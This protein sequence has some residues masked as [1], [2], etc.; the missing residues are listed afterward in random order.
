M[1]R[2]KLLLAAMQSRDDGEI[3]ALHRPIN[4]RMIWRLISLLA[5]W[6]QAYVGVAVAGLTI[7]GLEMIPPRLVGNCVNLIAK[8]AFSMRPVLEVAAV[9]TGLTLVCQ[10]LHSWQIRQ[11]CTSGESALAA[12][13]QQMFD[14][15][16]RLSMAYYDRVHPGRIIARATSDIDAV[17]GVLAWGFNTLC[18]NAVMMLLAAT[19]I[20]RTDLRLFLAVAWL[21]PLMS[22]MQIRF[23]RKIGLGW[24]EV[25]RHFTTQSTN[26]AE[27]I[28]GVRVVAAFNRQAENLSRYTKM[29]VINTANNVEVSA[30]AG[31]FSPLLQGCRFFGQATL[32][33]YGAYLVTT[34]RLQAGDVV[35]AALYWEGFMQPAINF[36]NFFNELMMAMAGAER[37]FSLLD[38]P[39]TNEDQPGAEPLPRLKGQVRFDHVT[40]AYQEGHPV[41]KD[42]QF[43]VPAGS[44]VALVGTTGSGKSTIIALLA[45]FYQP[46]SGRILLDGHDLATATATSLHAQMAMVLQSNHLFSGTVLDNLRYGKPSATDGELHEAARQ[47]GCHERFL[48]LKDGYDTHVGERGAALSL[49]ERQLVCFT[50]ALVASPRLLLLDEA[51]SA[52][53]CAAEVELQ[54]ALQRL[55]RSRTTFI[56][57]HR[58]S[59]IVNADMILVMEGGRIAETGTHHE[60]LG[61]QQGVYAGLCRHGPGL[62]PS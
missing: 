17:R 22:W 11:A 56:V 59:T 2:S 47:L 62:M 25:R 7:A 10:F 33:L 53:D 6:R 23:G 29:Q 57:A 26:Q 14:H 12:M 16:Q 58:L 21:A 20:C 24:Q 31:G 54:L 42:L 50:R 39:P 27:N 1:R 3:E 52:V 40:F 34:T 8:G 28:A 15:L 45:R 55:V 13:R 19:M 49:G 37:L 44:T 9:W 38:E 36:G 41:I 35:A 4:W 43:D 18:A 48:A 46:Q 51:T 60:L 30:I 5:P 32:L 61:K